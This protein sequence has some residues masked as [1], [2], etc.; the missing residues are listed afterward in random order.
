MIYIEKIIVLSEYGFK[1]SS[2]P[3]KWISC[4]KKFLSSKKFKD[5]KVGDT[6]ISSITNPNG[7]VTDVV[8]LTDHSGQEC[9][10]GLNSP[11]R[12]NLKA[13]LCPP[14]P[15]IKANDVDRK[16]LKG[17]C[18]KIAFKD[19]D[20]TDSNGRSNGIRNAKKLFVELEEANFYGW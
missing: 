6:F 20:V 4:D 14:S 17:Q 9:E 18:L 7:F 19:V 12:Q 13:S 16:I 2:N 15:D 10:G 11:S 1:L 5:I 3:E 8:I